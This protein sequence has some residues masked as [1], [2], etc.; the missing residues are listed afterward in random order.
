MTEAS[1][2]WEGQIVEG[3]F[4]LRLLGGSVKCGVLTGTARM[5]RSCHQSLFQRIG[6]SRSATLSGDLPR[7]C[8]IH[9]LRLF[10]TGRCSLGGSDLLYLV[11]EYAEENLSE[12]FPN[13]RLRRRSAR[14]ALPGSDASNIFTAKDL[15]MATRSPQISWP[16]GII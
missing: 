11:M 3:V 1:K 5:S 16:L 8:L 2:R 13:A 7:N 9:P 4:P 12:F 10:R 15:S 14:H 6:N